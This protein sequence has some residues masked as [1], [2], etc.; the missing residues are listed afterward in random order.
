MMCQ[1]V[2]VEVHIPC[3]LT[4]LQIH[5]YFFFTKTMIKLQ[6]ELHANSERDMMLQHTMNLQ[7]MEIKYLTEKLLAI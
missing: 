5:V 2:P 6:N 7:T 3:P 4:Q 1:K